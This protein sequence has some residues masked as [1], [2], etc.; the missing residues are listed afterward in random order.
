MT[1]PSGLRVFVVED[2]ELVLMM[3]ET[4]LEELGCI[5]TGSAKSVPV[6]LSAVETVPFDL[7]LLDVNLEGV[8][9]FP[10]AEAIAEKGLP[11][12]ISSGY[13]REG[14]PDAL[15]HVPI[16]PKPFR[17]EELDEAIRQ[18]FTPA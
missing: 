16:I 4:M 7:A 10:V 3:I 8:K 15:R 1:T 2:E 17:L 13:G 6:A 14:V 5:V 12:I 9:V 18:A 11:F